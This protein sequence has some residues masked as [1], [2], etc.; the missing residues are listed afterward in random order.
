[1]SIEQLNQAARDGDING[2]YNVI[3]L[4]ANILE[5][6]DA[7]PFVDTPLHIAALVGGSENIKFAMEVMRLKP[8]FS[9]KL[10]PD[11]LS[12]IHLALQAGH[13]QM[14][15]RLLQVDADLV[16]V[17]GREG[18]TP[19]HVVAEKSEQHHL[20]VKFLS[21]CPNS[22]ED[23]TIQNQTAMHIALEGNNM[24]AFE[25]LVTSLQEFESEKA[26]EILNQ[27][28]ENGKSV[29][30]V[31]ESKKEPK[32]SSLLSSIIFTLK[33]HC[34]VCVVNVYRASNTS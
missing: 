34:K 28:D 12:P 19:L 3:K 10:N 24:E 33:K 2:I 15:C 14:V 31:A 32:A 4:V 16:R 9:R 27:L 17:K 21:V 8:S 20:L 11:G 22:I 1:M 13:T 18:K 26:R 6:I 30:V 23:V 25:C 29:L 5:V 7:I